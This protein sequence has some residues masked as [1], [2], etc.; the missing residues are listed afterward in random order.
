[1]EEGSRERADPD[2]ASHQAPRLVGDARLQLRTRVAWRGEVE[3]RRHVAD[4][5]PA[6]RTEVRDFDAE[7]R[8]DQTQLRG[9]IEGVTREQSAA[10]VR[11][12]DEPRYAEAEPD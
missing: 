9:V 7:A 6:P 11:R 2:P 8:L 10:R 3:R 1:M 4:H 5:A 12:D